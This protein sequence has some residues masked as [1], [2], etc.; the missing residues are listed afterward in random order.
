MSF[1]SPSKGDGA[2]NGG[3]KIFSYL[4]GLQSLAKQGDL[5]VERLIEYIVLLYVI[6]GKT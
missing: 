2:V 5:F 6:P 4:P 1:K 3:G